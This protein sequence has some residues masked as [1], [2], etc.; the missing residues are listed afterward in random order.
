MCKIYVYI[1]VYS[2]YYTLHVVIY[3]SKIVSNINLMTVRPI[4]RPTFWFHAFIGL[5]HWSPVSSCPSR[6]I[7]FRLIFQ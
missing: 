4:A 6:L 5:R 7:S 3:T 1:R 2:T